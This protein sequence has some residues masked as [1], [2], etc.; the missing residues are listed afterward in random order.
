MVSALGIIG[1]VVVIFVAYILLMFVASRFVIPYLGFSTQP[2]PKRIPQAMAVAIKRLSKRYTSREAYFKGVFNYLISHHHS[3]YG[4]IIKDFPLLFQPVET[5]WK[6]KMIHCT[7]F[8]LLLRIF[9]VRSGKFSDDDI[10]IRH[11]FVNFS[12]HQYV[13][14]LL[15]GKWVDV[16]VWGH[17][18]G[19]PIGKHTSGIFL[20]HSKKHVFV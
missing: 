11:T 14:L 16:D 7:S 3:E 19:V 6:K 1:V 15:R 5:I 13:Q 9:L 8:V 17:F 18:V 4:G 20:R 12:I 2:L 10:R